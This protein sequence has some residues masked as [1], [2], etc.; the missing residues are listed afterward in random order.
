MGSRES[1]REREI[2]IRLVFANADDDQ[3]PLFADALRLRAKWRIAEGDPA[4]AAEA[5]DLVDMAL[6][7]F[8]TLPDMVLRARA[9]ASAGLRPGLVMTLH[10]LL[11]W[12]GFHERRRIAEEVLV[13]ID[14]AMEREA[15][16]DP[17]LADLRRQLQEIL[18][19]S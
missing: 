14:D 3:D 6:V 12:P 1:G 13:I 17:E 18:E 5:L 4:L 16:D 11:A 15:R 10:Q 7:T 2:A 8:G 19:L 9:V